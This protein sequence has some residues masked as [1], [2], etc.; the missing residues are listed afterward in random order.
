MQGWTWLPAWLKS[1]PWDFALHTT[2]LGENC[3]PSCTREWPPRADSCSQQVPGQGH[4]CS[5]NQ[6]LPWVA[7]SMGLLTKRKGQRKGK[8]QPACRNQKKTRELVPLVYEASHPCP[9]NVTCMLLWDLIIMRGPEHTSFV[10]A[11]FLSI[12]E[13]ERQY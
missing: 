10:N 6:N 2:I 12:A 9:S 5:G 7:H 1:H 4:W 13:A 8:R 3:K 11:I